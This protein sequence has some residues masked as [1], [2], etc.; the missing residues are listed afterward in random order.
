MNH[1]NYSYNVQIQVEAGE[2][3]DPLSC[4]RRR[5]WPGQLILQCTALPLWRQ[6]LIPLLR[7]R[8]LPETF[9][10]LRRRSSLTETPGRYGTAA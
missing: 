4:R 9:R 1:F 6:P 8:G 5:R 7:R 3:R 2:G 10:P